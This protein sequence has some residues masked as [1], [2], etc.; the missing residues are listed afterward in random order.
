MDLPK[1]DVT[2]G[3]GAYPNRDNRVAIG[4]LGGEVPPV[5]KGLGD[6]VTVGGILLSA[7]PILGPAAVE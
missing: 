6:G 4:S 7:G 3:D 1:V 2:R 5:V